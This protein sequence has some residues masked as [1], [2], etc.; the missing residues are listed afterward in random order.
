MMQDPEYAALYNEVSDLLSRAEA[1]TEAALIDAEQDLSTANSEL[2]QTLDKAN[3]LPD[4]TAVFRS[5]DGTI[6]TENGKPVEGEE[7]AGVVWKDKAPSYA[8]F[9]MKKRASETARERN[10]EFRR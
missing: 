9:L 5:K 2:D 3:R 6:Y 1:A 7:A 4:G 10:E 8:D